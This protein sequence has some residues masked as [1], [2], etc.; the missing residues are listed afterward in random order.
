MKANLSRIGSSGRGGTGWRWRHGRLR[1]LVAAGLALCSTLG[2]AGSAL[3]QT[4]NPN[5]WVTNGPVSA[6]VRDGGTIY[7]GGDFTRVGPATGGGVPLDAT[8]GSLQPFFPKVAGIVRV[9]IPDGSGGW[10]I[11]GS[12]TYVG[13]LP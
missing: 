8:T 2:G 11:G 13:G 10:Y 5:L 4:V 3:G 12:F 9:A 1:T 7:V 6:V